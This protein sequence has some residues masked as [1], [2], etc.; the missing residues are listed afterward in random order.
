MQN[1][2]HDFDPNERVSEN[3]KIKSYKE[4]KLESLK[5]S[6]YFNNLSMYDKANK[7]NDCGTWLEF[8]KKPTEYKDF[9]KLNRANFCRERFCPF[10]ANRLKI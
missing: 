2:T 1:C 5:A 9:T 6:Q 4:L 8:L 3:S 7:L 10:C